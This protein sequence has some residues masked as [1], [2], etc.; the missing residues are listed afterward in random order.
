MIMDTQ[1]INLLND[2][3]VYRWGYCSYAVLKNLYLMYYFDDWIDDYRFR[4][5]L[6][7]L[8]K[9]NEMKLIR[10]NKR[11]YYKYKDLKII[12][13]GILHFD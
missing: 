1:L 6:N 4:K 13:N 12:Q 9:N 7:E 3:N 10:K 2:K 5:I 8:I 11:Y